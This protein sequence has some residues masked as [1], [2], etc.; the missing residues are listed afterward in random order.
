MQ[1]CRRQSL[2]NMTSI[3]NSQLQRRKRA[4]LSKFSA[5]ER[6]RKRHKQQQKQLAR[7]YGPNEDNYSGGSGLSVAQL[8]DFR[9]EWNVL[10]Q[11]DLKETWPKDFAAIMQKSIEDVEGGQRSAFSFFMYV[12]SAKRLQCSRLLFEGHSDECN[13]EARNS[14]IIK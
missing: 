12:Y 13:F 4:L 6:Q 3:R 9:E 10:M 7:L 1:S 11:K 14:L 8:A 5:K 2:T